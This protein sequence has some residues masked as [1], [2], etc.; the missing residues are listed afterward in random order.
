MAWESPLCYGRGWDPEQG[1]RSSGVLPEIHTFNPLSLLSQAPVEWEKRVSWGRGFP[2]PPD[3]LVSPL[4][5]STSIRNSSGRYLHSMSQGLAVAAGRCSHFVLWCRRC[6]KGLWGVRERPG[7]GAGPRGFLRSQEAGPQ[8]NHPWPAHQ[9]PLEK[10]GSRKLIWH[11]LE[12]SEGVF[13]TFLF[14]PNNYVDPNDL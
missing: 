1:S 4:T 11:S 12:W 3:L 7:S 2:L 5:P 10:R 14:P 13:Y 6:R 8:R 9:T